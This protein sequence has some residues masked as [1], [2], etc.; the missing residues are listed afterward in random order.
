MIRSAGSGSGWCVAATTVP[1]AGELL[2]DDPREQREA[3]MV[4]RRG[5]FI[6]QP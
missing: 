3:G 6:E 1:P 4:E 2:R 5:G